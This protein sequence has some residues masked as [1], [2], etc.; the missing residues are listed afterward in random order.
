MI[1]RTELTTRKRTATLDIPVPVKRRITAKQP[2]VPLCQEACVRA[3]DPLDEEVDDLARL[4]QGSTKA[5]VQAEAEE[6][7]LKLPRLSSASAVSEDACT[8]DDSSSSSSSSSSEDEAED[9]ADGQAG[10]EVQGGSSEAAEADGGNTDAFDQEAAA[11][12]EEE[13]EEEA[14]IEREI[15]RLFEGD[16]DGDREIEF[17]AEDATGDGEVEFA[18]EDGYEAVAG[19]GPTGEQEIQ[20]AEDEA[21]EACQ[22]GLDELVEGDEK[23]QESEAE[24]T[25]G[26]EETAGEADSDAESDA[27][28]SSS[29]SS[30]AAPELPDGASLL[31]LI[32][33]ASGDAAT[34]A[35]CSAQAE[36]PK[37]P[38]LGPTERGLEIKFLG[39][40][41]KLPKGGAQRANR[42]RQLAQWLR[43]KATEGLSGVKLVPVQ[44]EG[45]LARV[46]G[47]LGNLPVPPAAVP[48]ALGG[49]RRSKA[50]HS[51]ACLG[52]TRQPAK[53]APDSS[54]R[55]GFAVPLHRDLPPP[56]RSSLSS[57]GGSH[58]PV[59]RS[60]SFEEER[61]TL[62]QVFD[63]VSH[64]Y[65]DLWFMNP[66]QQI[67]CNWCGEEFA[68]ACGILQG[69]EGRSQF[70]QSMFVCHPC[71]QM[72]G[73]VQSEDDE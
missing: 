29:S 25:G 35:P 23:G 4:L 17:A 7:Q 6:E 68:Q 36:A 57:R 62:V 58:P 49:S 48:G 65:E 41:R 18:A 39:D 26:D 34:S 19:E 42:F 70:A 67:V 63:V 45:L 46:S 44:V 38:Q 8:A 73:E 59:R 61:R 10:G 60:V 30:A 52:V 22:D 51:Q 56:K 3:A 15:T 33:N 32:A 11:E 55:P 50:A 54:R 21:E 69:E 16:G 5:D 72:D 64:R 31:D 71:L 1:D 9:R 53:E 43:S 28:S 27:S 47:Q 37:G 14:K 13:D 2:V 66:G 12:A 40:L 20:F 24:E